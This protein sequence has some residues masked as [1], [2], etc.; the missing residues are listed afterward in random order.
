MEKNKKESDLNTSTE[1]F[2]EISVVFCF[3]E[4]LVTIKKEEKK[5]EEKR[6]DTG[7]KRRES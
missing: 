2:Q 6:K 1:G 7:I 3:G 4:Y 5:R